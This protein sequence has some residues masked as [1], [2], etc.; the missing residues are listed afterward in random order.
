MKTR[1]NQLYVCLTRLKRIFDLIEHGLFLQSINIYIISISVSRS[2]YGRELNLIRTGLNTRIALSKRQGYPA[3]FSR[4]TR[5]VHFSRFSE[6]SE[7]DSFFG[8]LLPE[9]LLASLGNLRRASLPLRKRGIRLFISFAGINSDIYLFRMTKDDEYSKKTS[10]DSRPERGIIEIVI[11]LSA[12]HSAES[13]RSYPSWPHAMRFPSFVIRFNG[14][15]ENLPGR[16][17]PIKSARLARTI[18]DYSQ[19]GFTESNLPN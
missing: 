14:N 4:I 12:I 17:F 11:S 2:E 7:C 13:S 3:W 18:L 15:R 1:Y 19:R 9:K 8:F 5:R 6:I 10:N 16:K